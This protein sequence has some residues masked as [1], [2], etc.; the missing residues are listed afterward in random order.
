MREQLSTLVLGAEGAALGEV[1]TLFSGLDVGAVSS[2]QGTFAQGLDLVRE[3]VPDVVAIVI[4]GDARAAFALMEEISAAAPSAYIFALSQDDSTEN[5][6]KSMRAGATEF[7]SLPLD[8][9]QVLKAIIKVTALRRLS[10]PTGKRG[11]AWTIYSPKGG[12]GTTTLAANLAVEVQ[13]QGGKSVCL[14][15]LDFQSSDLALFLNVN[16]VYTMMDIALN[17]RRL[18]SVFLQG[19]LTRH[20]SGVYLLAAPP[21]GMET[22]PIPVEQVR[23]VL[24]LLRTMY[25]VV[26]IDTPRVLSEDTLAAFS[27]ASRVLLVIELTLPFLRGYR[28]TR[29][30]LDALEVPADRTDVVITKYGASR[31]AVPLDEAKRTLG[32]SVAHMLPRDDETALAAVNKGIPL[33]D[34]KTNTPLRRSIADLAQMLTGANGAGEERSKKRKGMFGGLFAS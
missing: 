33:C 1:S 30:V 10:Q 23:A 24:D 21:H 5:I 29:D 19:T 16:P 3:T 11:E 14:V 28:R 32:L 6:V 27:M 20:A 13:A 12:A 8:A 22:P 7:L 15:D 4:D 31:A 18:D 9:S 2:V 17:F 25:D 26:I 34:V